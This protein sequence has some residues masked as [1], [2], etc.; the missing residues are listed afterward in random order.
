MNILK[1]L[2]CIKLILLSIGTI[3]FI[4]GIICLINK[5]PNANIIFLL[6]SIFSFASTNVNKTI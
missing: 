1:L 5:T 2:L 6:S 3:L 4:Y